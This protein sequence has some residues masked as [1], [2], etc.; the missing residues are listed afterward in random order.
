MKVLMLSTD[1]TVFTPGSST[2]KR[3]EEYAETF[4][5]LSVIVL[6]D[7]GKTPLI[8]ETLSLYPTNSPSRYVR[9]RD[10]IRIGKEF[11]VP[12]VVTAEDPFET[13][14]AASK[15]AH[16]LNAPLHIQV[17]TDFIAS[18]FAK[19]HFPFNRLRLLIAAQVLKRADR[20]RVVSE[21]IKEKIERKY[22]PKAPISVIPIYV[23]IERY[24]NM[25]KTRHPKFKTML[26]VV[27]RLEKEKPLRTAIEAL[28]K[29]RDAGIDCGLVIVGAG[30]QEG[31]LKRSAKELGVSAWVEFTG[32]Q[33]SVVPYYAMADLVLHLGAS[34]EGYG[35][36]IIESL[37]GGVPVLSLDVGIAKQA[38][39]MIAS[40]DFGDALVRYLKSAASK[41]PAR[42]LYMPY[43][44]KEEYL[45]KYAE[46][47]ALS[48]I[49]K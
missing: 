34:Y 31:Y 8:G 4:G 36:G 49:P 39:A 48:R 47:L 10:A 21:R 43:A 12:D 32:F 9:W 22:H 13:G 2:R 18:G 16:A 28:K 46:D 6:C 11:P 44:S 38:G 1:R 41:E 45:R 30:R 14:L 33:N 19:A 23:D 42:L 37:A 26:L 20:I 5:S 15:I 27:S 40:G 29:A 24:R 35:M 25:E 17:H 7:A 3:M